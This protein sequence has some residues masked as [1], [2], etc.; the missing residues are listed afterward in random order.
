MRNH[1]RSDDD[2]D[3]FDEDAPL[4]S[5]DAI[6][7]SRNGPCSAGFCSMTVLYFCVMIINGA[8]IGA[9]GPSLQHIG[10]D[11]GLSDSQLARYVLQNRLCKLAGTLIW[12]WY[13]RRLQQPRGFARPHAM[14][15]GLMV[16]TTASAVTL[17]A[18]TR[19][20]SVQM[21]LLAWGIAYGISDSGVSSACSTSLDLPRPH[22]PCPSQCARDEPACLHVRSTHRVAVGPRQPS[23]ADRRRI[24]QRG[25]Y[26]WGSDR[27]VP[28][29]R[30]AAMAR[31]RRRPVGVPYHRW[32]RARRVLLPRRAARRLATG[33][34]LAARECDRA[35]GS[36]CCMRPRCSMTFATSLL[37]LATCADRACHDRS[38]QK[39]RSSATGRPAAATAAATATRATQSTRRS[40]PG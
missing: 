1:Y 27:A 23:A 14:F 12:C 36:R 19:P 15:A 21:A 37:T 22:A 3:D 31:A 35:R 11:V 13:A 29:R 40:R 39:I 38:L 4:L 20:A 9:L 8:L 7:G 2:S 24:A 32:R 25:I 16:V 18:A 5:S 34:S 10:R 26:R 6:T 33:A 17:G 28:R 30:L